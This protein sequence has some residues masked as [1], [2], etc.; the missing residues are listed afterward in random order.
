[1]MDGAKCWWVMWEVGKVQMGRGEEEGHTKVWWP[2]EDEDV[3]WLC[4]LSSFAA[5]LLPL[6][7][8]RT[9]PTKPR[10]CGIC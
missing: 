2:V 3:S 9:F 5:P 4:L 8:P 6:N 10:A 1:M 7:N